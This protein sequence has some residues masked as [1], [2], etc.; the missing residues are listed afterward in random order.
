MSAP[1][2]VALA[3]ALALEVYGG[4]A[5]GLATALRAGLPV[6]AGFA[7]AAEALNEL[8]SGHAPEALRDTL[9]RMLAALG[10]GALAVRSSAVGEDA[11]GAS[12]A[13]QHATVLGPRDAHGVLVALARVHDSAYTAEAAAYRRRLGLPLSPRIGAVV[14][15]LI[16][17]DVAGV[18]F[19][20]DPAGG[21]HIVVEAS[22]GLGE[23]VVTGLVTPD[24]FVL[25][26]DGT[27]L[28]QRIGAKTAAVRAD[29]ASGT[30]RREPVAAELADRA[31]LGQE[32][33]G[34]LADLARRAEDALG[35]GQD[36]EWALA[37]AELHL[38]QSRPIG[39]LKR[40][41]GITH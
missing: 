9:D 21:E 31:C 19:T 11:A 6:P 22:L 5:G 36:V 1:P 2:L 37:G 17:A 28:G 34:R 23:S 39:T 4:K 27:L 15:R 25:E 41:A 40:A 35:P 13:G 16:A 8:A 32:E 30:T 3:D 29:P 14:Q 38:L 18:I 33:L 20:R 7:I 12:F 24:H 10:A 26:R